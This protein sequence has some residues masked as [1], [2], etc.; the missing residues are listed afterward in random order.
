MCGIAGMMRR[1]GAFAPKAIV[2][3][4][5]DALAHRGPDGEGIHLQGAVALAH[6]RLSIIDLQ[7]GD[8]PFFDGAG[9]TLIGKLLKERINVQITE[10]IPAQKAIGTI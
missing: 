1:G 10:V 2:Q 8:Q 4:M 7:T 6:R 3:Q 5:I 9:N